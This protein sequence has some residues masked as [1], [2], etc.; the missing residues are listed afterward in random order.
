MMNEFDCHAAC[1][2]VFPSPIGELLL[3]SDGSAL[4]GLHMALNR[5]R[6]TAHPEPGCPR[7]DSAFR[8]AREQLAAYF[9]RELR[10]F[11]LLLSMDGTPFQRCVWAELR[12]IPYGETIS[13][14]ELAR[15]IGRPG[16]SRAVGSANG[17]N[18]IAIVVPCHRVI[19]A[20]GTLGGYGGGLDRKEWLLGLE[21][22][23]VGDDIV[24]DRVAK[25]RS[26]GLSAH[27]A[28]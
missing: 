2:S 5:G 20:D 24:F 14:A 13:Y 4:T 7:D 23:E 22:T 12:R 3:T 25:K 1:Y 17:R 28:V 6:P 10:D 16:A 8:Q 27:S 18:P 11:E 26:T 15:R 9:A 21:G 19:A